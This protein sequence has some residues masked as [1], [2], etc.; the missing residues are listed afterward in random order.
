MGPFSRSRTNRAGLPQRG[1]GG[2]QGYCAEN[3]SLVGGNSMS[4]CGVGVE[5]C[6]SH[7]PGLG[8]A[9]RG[10]GQP[11]H[12]DRGMGSSQGGEPKERVGRRGGGWEMET[13]FQ[14]SP[15]KGTC[16][17]GAP[18]APRP[19]P[20]SALAGPR[21]L[22]LVRATQAA[23]TGSRAS[24]SGW[25]LTR[26]Q[27]S[28][29]PGSPREAPRDRVCR[30]PEWFHINTLCSPDRRV[31]RRPEVPVPCGGAVGLASHCL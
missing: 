20:A 12:E 27:L 5:H 28:P 8:E 18:P 17:P 2:L 3:E 26:G 7:L 13:E 14:A 23:G 16:S 31:L 4:K 19:G 24:I 30:V 11:L 21:S 15:W 1:R 25:S 6:S 10:L 9:G 22:W 29:G